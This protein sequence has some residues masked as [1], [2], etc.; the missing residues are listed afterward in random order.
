MHNRRFLSLG[1]A[2]APRG[3]LCDLTAV[4]MTLDRWALILVF[5]FVAILFAAVLPFAPA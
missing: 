4:Q 3:L 1:P 5:S 2:P